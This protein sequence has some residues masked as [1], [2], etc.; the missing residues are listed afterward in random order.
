[1]L[2]SFL[3]LILCL[4][5]NTAFINLYHKPRK[6]SVTQVPHT[7]VLDTGKLLLSPCYSLQSNCHQ[8]LH[9]AQALKDPLKPCYNSAL[10]Q[11]SIIPTHHM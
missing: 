1:M 7:T 11:S 9:I 10:C 6:H 8:K 5:Q 3:S 4:T 2:N